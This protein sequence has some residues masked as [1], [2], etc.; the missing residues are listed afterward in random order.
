MRLPL[1][2]LVCAAKRAIGA[3]M[4]DA[5]MNRTF[6]QSLEVMADEAPEEG[7]TLHAIFDRLDE[8]A[9]GAGLFILALPRSS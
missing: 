3:G 8:R 6:L 5:S 9:F 7:I 2:W 1:C 4:T